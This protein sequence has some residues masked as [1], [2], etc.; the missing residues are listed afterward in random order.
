MPI[1]KQVTEIDRTNGYP[2]TARPTPTFCWG[3]FAPVT[4]MQTEWTS[5]FFFKSKKDA[6]THG[7]KVFNV[8]AVGKVQS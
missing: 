1:T 6:T 7:R 8:F 5:N 3:L 4:S 2:L